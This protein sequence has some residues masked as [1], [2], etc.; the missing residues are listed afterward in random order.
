MLKRTLFFSSLLLIGLLSLTACLTSGPARPTATA[1]PTVAPTVAAVVPTRAPTTLPT[2]AP[3][4]AVN[5]TPLSQTFDPIAA[6][7]RVIITWFVGLGAGTQPEQIPLQEAVV[8]EFNTSQDSIY[9]ALEVIDNSAAF[10]LLAERIAVGEVPDIIGP[11]GLRGR[12]G[13]AGQLLDLSEL[14]AANDIDLS[15]YPPE[16]VELYNVPGQGQIGLPYAIYPSFLYFNKQL[17]DAAEL[18]YPP[19]EYGTGYAGAEWN[20][21]TLRELAMQLTLDAAGNPATSPDFDPTRIVQFGFHP[22]FVQDDRAVATLFGAGSLVDAEGN[23]Q[24]PANWRAA[25]NWYHA[26]MHVDHFA[27]SATYSSS[28][29]FGRGNVFN[30]GKLAMAWS[31]S[32]YTCCIGQVRDWDIAAMPTY[33][34]QVTAKI[35]ADTFAIMRE[36]AHPQEAFAVLRYLLESPQLAAAYGAMP[37]QTSA[38]P[39]YFA[40]LNAKFAATNQSRVNWQVAVDSLAYPDVPSHE[41][42]LPNFL[43]AQ[44]ELQRFSLAM[45]SEP[46]LAI[47]AAIDELQQRLQAIFDASP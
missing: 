9:L 34:G 17:F 14:I 11:V 5:T 30:S 37:A 40:G 39:D 2:R 47:D 24:I 13:F 33:D 29:T 38:Q 43:A 6:G 19:Q 42:D 1:E 44:D 15:V 28:A 10:N 8:R 4:A 35:H 18:P 41:E 21:A 23:A 22:Q 45:R 25:W 27:P 32:W 36:T 12:N 20:M 16:L 46:D 3:T 31:H 26:A 7:D